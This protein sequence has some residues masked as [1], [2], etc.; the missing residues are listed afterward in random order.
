[1][2]RCETC[3]E[4]QSPGTP[5]NRIPVETRPASYPVRQKAHWVPRKGDK[6]AHWAED[7]GGTGR[8]IVREVGAC[9]RCAMRQAAPP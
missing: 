4:Q 7:P 2:Y 3:G 8:E 6:A 1:M 9:A 5:L